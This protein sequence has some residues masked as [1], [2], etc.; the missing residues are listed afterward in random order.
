MCFHNFEINRSTHA[1]CNAISFSLS[2]GLSVAVCHCVT[3][4]LS[5]CVC[6]NLAPLTI[7]PL[8]TIPLLILFHVSIRFSSPLRAILFGSFLS[9]CLSCFVLLSFF[10][11]IHLFI[12]IAI[13][14]YIKFGRGR[15][16]AC[17]CFSWKWR[18]ASYHI[19]CRLR[20]V[21]SFVAMI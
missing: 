9:S 5:A 10:F 21:R 16:C 15:I 3:H 11:S 18:D 6:M 17:V 12:T 4:S 20:C 7:P 2:V 14:M 19:E 13:T 8:I 1:C